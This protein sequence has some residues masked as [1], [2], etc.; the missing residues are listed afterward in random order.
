[1]RG[2]PRAL[3][4]T[5]ASGI[6]LASASGAPA[7]QPAPQAD[8]AVQVTDNPSPYR[9]HATPVI[10]A[11]PEDPHVIAIAEG[12]ARS[13]QCGVR[14]STNAGLSWRTAASPQP[15][16]WP[17]CVRNTQG[18]IADLAFTAQ[19]E[20]LMA[21]PGWKPDDWHSRIFLSRSTDL[22]RSWETTL[23]PGLEPPYAAA[24]S[25]SNALP[26]VVVDPSRPSRIYVTWSQ[27][28]GLWNLEPLL[29]DGKKQADYPRRPMVAI[30]EDGGTTFSRPADL[31][32]D[33]TGWLTVPNL[34]VGTNGDLHAFFGEF[35]GPPDAKEAR[36]Y[37]AT[38]RDDGRTWAQKSVHTMP[39]GASFAFLLAPSV[40]VNPTNGELYVAWEDAG[41]RPPAVL[42]MRSTDQGATW[43]PPA[44]LNDKDPQRMWDFK[45]FN[46]SIAVAPNG[47]I[48][49]VWTDWRD[50]ITFVPAPGQRNVL[51]HVYGT[52][53]NDGGRTW[54]PNFRITDRAIDR[55]LSVW[56]TGVNGPVGLAST[57][58]AGYVAWDDS[59]NS[60]VESQT[61]DVY[62]SRVRHGNSVLAA[63]PGV[64]SAGDKL[65]WALL[66]ASVALVIGGAALLLARRS[67]AG[68]PA[69]ALR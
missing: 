40:A 38:S 44:K 53:S 26:S 64:P 61:Q 54:A 39:K 27:N 10:A 60:T 67:A 68:Q 58:A 11:D 22:G 47:R 24:D 31:A 66:G 21:F 12:D 33:T 6:L 43:A 48:D 25:G 2:R 34:V 63:A 19:G 49:A 37:Q 52:Y 23:I 35:Q 59:R 30:S 65:L 41:S 17:I 13:G 29:P 62:F 45:E 3:A 56:S 4:W 8:G 15:S 5:L 50:D 18:G 51:Q 20:L 46:P 36:L 42:F 14:V 57:D 69:A 9:A 16:D 28:Y 32:G 55:R 1:M 7:Q